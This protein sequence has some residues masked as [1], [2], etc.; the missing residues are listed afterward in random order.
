MTSSYGTVW[1]MENEDMRVQRRSMVL[2]V[3]MSGG[4][5]P[6][7]LAEGWKWGVWAGRGECAFSEWEVALLA[8]TIEMLILKHSCRKAAME[9]RAAGEEDAFHQVPSL[10]DA[11]P[12]KAEQGSLEAT[13]L[14]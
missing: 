14:C 7:V 8:A 9:V 11:N 5:C 12:W 10:S 3:K 4:R 2:N 6:G 1:N 13:Q